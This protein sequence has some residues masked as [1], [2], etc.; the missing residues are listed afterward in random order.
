MR[1]YDLQNKW[2]KLLTPDI[3]AL[4]TQI[5]ECKGEQNLFIEAHSDTLTRTPE[6]NRSG[7]N[8][9]SHQKRAGNCRLS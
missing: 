5:H 6:K 9:P 7:Q 1:N 3:V 2:Q 4:L 8:N